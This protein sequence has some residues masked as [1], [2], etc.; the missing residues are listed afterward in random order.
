[1]HWCVYIVW[2][3]YPHD[4]YVEKLVSGTLWWCHDDPGS[5]AGV[6][7]L[8]HFSPALLLSANQHEKAAYMFSLIV[9]Q[10]FCC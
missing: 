7:A 4:L 6:K 10:G 5:A 3:N 1:M 8:S 9:T 2:D